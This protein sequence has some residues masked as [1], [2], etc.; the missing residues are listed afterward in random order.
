M[1]QN[2]NYKCYLIAIV[3]SI[4]TNFVYG[5][6]EIVDLGN[7][8]AYPY[9]TAYSIN[10]AGQIV[11]WVDSEESLGLHT[12]AYFYNGSSLVSLGKT[13]GMAYSI[14]NHGQVVG[15]ARDQWG[16]TEACL[17][18][19]TSPNNDKFLGK[20]AAYESSAAYSI[21]NNGKIVGDSSY[22]ACLFDSSGAGNNVKL[23]T[24]GGN[25]SAALCINDN[26]LTV[27]WAENGSYI[28]HASIFDITGTGN[29]ID[30]GT[31]GGDSSLAFGCNS[32]GQIIGYAEDVSGDSVA[33]LFDPTGSGGN[34]SLGALGGSE[35]WALDINNN[36]QIVGWAD[37]DSE[38]RHAC[39]F[40]IT[41]AGENIDL[42]TLID[43]A[44]GLTLTYAYSINDNGWIVGEGITQDGEIHA[45][46]L[47]PEP[48]TLVLLSLGGLLIRRKKW[49][50]N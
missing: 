47:V 10:N 23:G 20:D 7:L 40:D 41:G 25:E 34:F 24:L 30:L 21:N 26:D 12:I 33:C 38:T 44:L 1:L 32:T 31:L 19:S 9:S 48:A 14:N 18:D 3:V 11:G 15:E 8:T 27:G 17:F 13:Y 6:R 16:Y 45:C 35:S 28:K 43:P 22:E 4:L 46:L 29:N 42:N 39:L 49:S 5:Y 2:T 50:T 37:I 36:G